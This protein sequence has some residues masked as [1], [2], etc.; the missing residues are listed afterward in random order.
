MSIV[1]IAHDL[2][3]VRHI[4]DRVAVMYLGEMVEIGDTEEVYRHPE[5]PYT[6]SLLSAIRRRRVPIAA[7]CSVGHA[8]RPEGRFPL[9]SGCRVGPSDR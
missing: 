9:L 4:A 3:L 7:C 1:F 8:S 2:S 5:H 6:R